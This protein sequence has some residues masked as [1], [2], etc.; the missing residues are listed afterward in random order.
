MKYR[1]VL[2]FAL[3]TGAI[4]LAQQP[5]EWHPNIAEDNKADTWEQTSSWLTGALNT[6]DINQTG[7]DII[8]RTAFGAQVQAQCSLETTSTVF[9]AKKNK[10]PIDGSEDRYRRLE[11]TLDIAKI[12]PL[13]I[14]VSRDAH[15]SLTVYHVYLEGMDRKPILNGREIRPHFIPR[16][17]N[18]PWK[19]C[20]GRYKKDCRINE[21]YADYRYEIYVA[22][23][24]LSKRLARALMHA[25]LLCGG[26]KAVSPF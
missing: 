17:F 24:D 25:A 4:A 15:P 2:C 10:Q 18:D 19:E 7:S 5:A 20:S 14:R 22:D 26:S 13:S 8:L 12:D 3:V 21:S 16:D 6:T 1:A 9:V 23:L 11:G